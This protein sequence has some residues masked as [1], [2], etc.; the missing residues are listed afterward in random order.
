M[1]GTKLPAERIALALGAA[2]ASLI[3]F[4]AL[5]GGCRMVAPLFQRASMWRALDAVIAAI[6]FVMAATTIRSAFPAAASSA[7][8]MRWVI[9][10][11]IGGSETACTGFP[12]I[13]ICLPCG[14]NCISANY[15]SSPARCL[16]H[17]SAETTAIR[18]IG[19]GGSQ[20]G[21]CKPSASV[22]SGEWWPA[23]ISPSSLPNIVPLST[24]APL[25]PSET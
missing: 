4:A 7:L 16:C 11:G 3:W 21:R 20:L 15:R 10:A 9:G 22:S 6:M 19:S 13:G 24:P 18:R 25:Q 12:D 23:A 5:I 8:L 1:G 14:K 17:F 2:S